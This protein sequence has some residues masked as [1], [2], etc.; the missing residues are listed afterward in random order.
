MTRI[1]QT[2]PRRVHTLL[3]VALLATT[4]T[5]G[6]T[7]SAP[8]AAERTE[9]TSTPEA[10][11]TRVP[12]SPH[13]GASTNPHGVPPNA[14]P[15]LTKVAADPSRMPND[16]IHAP[17]RA[18]RTGGTPR[19]ARGP[20]QVSG[21]TDG[22]ATLPLV[23]EGPRSI[24]E[25]NRRLAM[26]S[27]AALKTRLEKAFRLTFATSGDRRTQVQR[28]GDAIK[29]LGGV[30]AGT[31]GATAQRIIARASLRVSGSFVTMQSH[32]A[33][34]VQ[35]DPNYGAA[36]Y[37]LAFSL[38]AGATPEALKKGRLHYEKAMKLGVKDTNNI[39]RYFYPGGK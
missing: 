24:A 9:K 20:M 12:A 25:L 23:K 8:K 3:L 2:P 13:G 4:V 30:D 16:D 38:V 32:Y 5:L 18:R 15:K 10:K 17:F 39:R 37:G 33:N 6:C 27:D 22:H 35:L 26:E 1:L 19:P 7:K 11:V 31:A 36:H 14:Q 34:A 21:D 28:S 29:I